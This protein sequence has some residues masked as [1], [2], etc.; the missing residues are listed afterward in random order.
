[1]KTI[2]NFSLIAIFLILGVWYAWDQGYLYP[3]FEETREFWHHSAVIVEKNTGA[4]YK[5]FM[6]PFPFISLFR[7]ERGIPDT[8]YVDTILYVAAYYAENATFKNGLL[9]TQGNTKSV[10]IAEFQTF[11]GKPVEPVS[12]VPDSGSVHRQQDENYSYFG[13]EMG[14]WYSYTKSSANDIF[15]E[16]RHKTSGGVLN[17]KMGTACSPEMNPI[18]IGVGRSMSEDI[19][20]NPKY[21]NTGSKQPVTTIALLSPLLVSLAMSMYRASR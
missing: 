1:M 15:F 11:G 18:L 9:H 3:R 20:F 19:F 14:G 5:P 10:T 12:I 21:K 17:M 6:D 13:A 7:V 8:V 16:A 2:I 4:T